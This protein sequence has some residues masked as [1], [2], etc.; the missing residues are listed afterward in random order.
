MKRRKGVIVMPKNVLDK[1]RKIIL[2][3]LS[4]EKKVKELENYHS[5]DI[6]D[7]LQTLS[8]DERLKLY[9][10]I[11]IK[12]TADIFS[13]YDD[14]ENYI[15]ELDPE[16]AADVLEQMDADVAIEVLDELEEDSRDE[17][18]E[19]MD[20]DA[21]LQVQKLDA[22][23][24]DVIGSYCSDN[25]IV[26]SKNQS[27]TG[28]MTTLVQEAGEHDNINTLYV[29]DEQN[30]FYGAVSLRD[31]I[32]ARKGH[33]LLDLCKTS[34]PTFYDDELMSDCIGK[35]KEYG[36]SS[37]PVL[38][39][40]NEI[41][42]VI[43]S[44]S[45]I[46]ATEEELDEDYA[47]LAGLSESED[48]DES[49]FKSI[50]KRVPWLLILLFLGLAV[51]SVIGSFEGVIASLPVIVF[52]QSMILDMAGNV[53]TQSLAVTI[54]NITTNEEMD[55][56]KIWKNVFKELRVGFL[57]GLIV[58]VIGFAFVL[59]FLAIRHQEVVAGDGY[60]FLDTL[61]VAGIIAGSLLAAMTL[62]SFIG[63]SFPILLDKIHIDP[64]VASGPFIT[65]IN[66]IVAVV[67]YYGLAYL[68]FLLFI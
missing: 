56:K 11:G 50:R 54:R 51:S 5:S 20:T 34:F 27:I 59:A 2:S 21:K 40:N 47:K 28:A 18:I 49:T 42:G 7:V 48:L 23:D 31:L 39:H 53:G 61:K 44:D 35:L 65:T 38:N 32:V 41:V 57:N 64:A 13:F 12:K 8:K 25:Y 58:A 30:Q 10:I 60:L 43:T 37:I 19:L 67:V 63:T 6:A 46:D 36:E 15:A 29:V 26:I 62:S 66:D 14:V 22:Y 45:V 52:F 55:K 9:A 17:L 33:E 4:K 16:F 3:K 24:E 68:S 1:L